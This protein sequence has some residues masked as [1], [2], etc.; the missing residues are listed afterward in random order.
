MQ[1][2]TFSLHET[3]KS[4]AANCGLER[5]VTSAL[6]LSY[7]VEISLSYE[8]AIPFMPSCTTNHA[9][10]SRDQI[11]FDEMSSVKSESCH[12]NMRE[13][14]RHEKGSLLTALSHADGDI[15][16]RNMAGS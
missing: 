13:A 12:G 11:H 10:T 6:C 7:Q 1:F 15:C 8:I 9:H 4:S 2:I 16:L 5:W 14:R 3:L